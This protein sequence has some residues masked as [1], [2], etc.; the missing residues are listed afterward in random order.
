MAHAPK[1]TH[2]INFKGNKNF[3]PI[4]T[5]CIVVLLVATVLFSGCSSPSLNE[6]EKFTGTLT[7]IN[8]NAPNGWDF[9]SKSDTTTGKATNNLNGIWSNSWKYSAPGQHSAYLDVFVQR[10]EPASTLDTYDIAQQLRDHYALKKDSGYQIISK[11][12]ITPVSL[13]G[14]A[15]FSYE[16][17]YSDGKE[18]WLDT[19]YVTALPRGKAVLIYMINFLAMKEEYPKFQTLIDSAIQS[20]TIDTQ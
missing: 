11:S 9:S 3:L 5:F 4:N 1:D 16:V 14:R 15:G 8:M 18:T 20:F 17:S 2:L 13:S 7:N 10:I 12:D 6:T 19:R